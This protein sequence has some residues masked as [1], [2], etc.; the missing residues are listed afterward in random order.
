MTTEKACPPITPELLA[1]LEGVFPDAL[2]LPTCRIRDV[3]VGM[4]AQKVIRKLRQEHNRQHEQA[5]S[6]QP[7]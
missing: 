3:F 1:W 5:L 7:R 4:G 6:G 2:P